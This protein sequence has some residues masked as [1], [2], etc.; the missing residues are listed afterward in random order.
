MKRFDL[1]KR[2]ASFIKDKRGELSYVQFEKKYGISS[3]SVSRIESG[4]QN[5]TLKTLEDLCKT[6]KCDVS[7]LFPK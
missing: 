7:D 4:E 1:N 2:L 5:V 6:F 3:S